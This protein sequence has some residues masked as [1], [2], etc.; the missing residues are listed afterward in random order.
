M[1]T[2]VS[3]KRCL[4]LTGCCDCP[5]GYSSSS[6]SAKDNANA[7]A[8]AQ[9][10]LDDAE[11]YER[12]FSV[13]LCRSQTLLVLVQAVYYTVFY[14]V[15]G[16]NAFFYDSLF[17]GNGAFW[18][19]FCDVMDLKSKHFN[20]TSA[21][22]TVVFNSTGGDE[23]DATSVFDVYIFIQLGIE[24]ISFFTQMALFITAAVV[25]ACVRASFSFWNSGFGFGYGYGY[26]YG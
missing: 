21:N 12:Q 7:N 13:F 3:M 22:G 4:R 6:S 19:N 17:S 8:N 20:C 15:L 10:L 16:F 14:V 26:G 18:G 25:R 1:A 2:R 23:F 5:C 9:V 24:G 11:S